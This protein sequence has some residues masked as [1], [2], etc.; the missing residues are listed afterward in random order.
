MGSPNINLG[1]FED[2]DDD[3]DTT[4]AAAKPALKKKVKPSSLL[5]RANP[6]PSAPTDFSTAQSSG[7]STPPAASVSVEA[8]MGMR[9]SNVHIPSHLMEA[10]TRAR[11]ATGLSTGYLFIQAIEENY[12][13]VKASIDPPPEVGG[14]L[15]GARRSKVARS[16]TGPLTPVNYRLAAA[17]FETLDQL[18]E[19]ANASSRGHLITEALKLYLTNH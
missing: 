18:V 11:I 5:Q 13:P 7:S 4:T 16:G 2:I 12:A 10:L 9:P 19:A 17:D 6:V 1:G 8:N 14:S 15:F 3:M